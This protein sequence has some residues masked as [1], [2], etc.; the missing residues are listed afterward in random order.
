M[1]PSSNGMKKAAIQGK[2]F[3]IVDTTTPIAATPK[4]IDHRNTTV[5]NGVGR[6]ASPAAKPM[7]KYAIARMTQPPAAPKFTANTRNGM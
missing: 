1:S 7:A 3:S 5:P 6:F 2:D 4:T